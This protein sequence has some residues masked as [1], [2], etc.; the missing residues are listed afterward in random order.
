MK[1]YQV[2]DPYLDFVVDEFSTM[3]EAEK[4]INKCVN[5]DKKHPQGYTPSY[6]IEKRMQTEES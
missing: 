6:K 2:I 4:F 5:W 1:K 3:E